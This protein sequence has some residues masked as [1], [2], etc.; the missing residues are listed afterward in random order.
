[1]DGEL[2]IYDRNTANTDKIFERMFEFITKRE[3]L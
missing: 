1:M 3:I 2:V